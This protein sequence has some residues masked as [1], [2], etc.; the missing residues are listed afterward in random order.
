LN[1]EPTDMKEQ[2]YNRQNGTRVYY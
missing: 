2:R 1:T